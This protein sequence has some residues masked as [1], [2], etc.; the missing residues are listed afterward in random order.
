MHDLNIRKRTQRRLMIAALC[1]TCTLFSGTLGA[2]NYRAGAADSV[3]AGR[4]A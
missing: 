3:Q 1:S 2:L 4:L